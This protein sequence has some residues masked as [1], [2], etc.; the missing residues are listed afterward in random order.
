MNFPDESCLLVVGISPLNSRTWQCVENFRRKSK[1]L[2]R[3]SRWSAIAAQPSR[4]RAATAALFQIGSYL[5]KGQGGQ[6]R[7]ASTGT[8]VA[9][10]ADTAANTKSNS[11]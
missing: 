11:V 10:L 9:A 7:L 8:S 4:K 1:N 5:Q 6:P 2:W 3:E